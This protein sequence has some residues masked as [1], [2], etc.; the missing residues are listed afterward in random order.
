MNIALWWLI[1]AAIL[2]TLYWFAVRGRYIAWI[3]LFGA[4][5][6]AIGDIACQLWID[7]TGMFKR[8]KR[9]ELDEY[10]RKLS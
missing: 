9:L 1:A 8:R 7:V 4:V 2:L 6:G 10:E 3:A 5:G